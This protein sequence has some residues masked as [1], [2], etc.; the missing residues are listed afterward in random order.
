[1]FKF[2]SK[3]TSSGHS[4]GSLGI[5][6]ESTEYVANHLTD[7]NFTTIDPAQDDPMVITLEID[8]F[9][10]IKVLV[11]Q[12]CSV[13]I[14][15]W[16]N[17]K[18]MRIPDSEIQSY[19][20]LTIVSTPH[21]EMKF[22]LVAG[23]IVTVH[24]DQK[25]TRECYVANLKVE[26]TSR[27]YKTSSCGLSVGKRGRSPRHRE[28]TRERARDRRTKEHMVTFLVSHIKH[29][30]ILKADNNKLVS[31]TLINNVDLF[32]WMVVDMP[33][34]SPNIITHCLFIYKEAIAVA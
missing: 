7:D 24:V 6:Q 34:V 15:C 27:L 32:A 26:L 29:G 31:Q 33:G 16:K 13:D 30:N 9:V 12:G 23:D 1:M 4:V 18:K 22:S 17:F 5:H 2:R 10:I 28:T 19:L 11:D 21:L 14:L 3:K 20:M 25:T 8:K